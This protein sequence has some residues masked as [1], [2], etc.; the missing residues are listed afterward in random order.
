MMSPQRG[1]PGE[2]PGRPMQFAG[3]WY[4]GMGK[5]GALNQHPALGSSGRPNSWYLSQGA[6]LAGMPPP[7]AGMPVDPYQRARQQAMQQAAAG[8]PDWEDDRVAAMESVHQPV[9]GATSGATTATL[10][11]Y[12]SYGKSLLGDL[13]RKTGL[14]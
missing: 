5:N 14:G 4:A 7:P 2:I 13:A 12:V 9:H 8:I 3:S 1:R 6:M 11:D 10:S